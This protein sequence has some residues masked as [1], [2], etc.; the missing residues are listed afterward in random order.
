MTSF[1]SVE[2]IIHGKTTGTGWWWLEHG[3]CDFPFSWECHH[4]NRRTHIFQRA[5]Y[6]TNQHLYM[7][8]AVWRI[9]S[10]LPKR[11]KWVCLQ[12]RVPDGTQYPQI[13]WQMENVPRERDIVGYVIHFHHISCIHATII[14]KPYFYGD[15]SKPWYLLFTPSHSWDLWM[16]IPL[17]MLFS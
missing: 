10:L 8:Y 14:C 5:R 4:P 12:V 1:C 15:C 6:T 7:R 11:L 9:L 13:H 3:F 17:K 16:F 2:F